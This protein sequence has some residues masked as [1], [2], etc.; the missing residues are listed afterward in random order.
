ML[1]GTENLNN[2]PIKTETD[3]FTKVTNDDQECSNVIKPEKYLKVELKYEKTPLND[4]DC[5]EKTNTKLET[6][7]YEKTESN[8]DNDSDDNNFESS[9]EHNES[10]TKPQQQ[11]S[12]SN[13]KKFFC[14]ICHSSYKQLMRLETHMI[15]KH[16][17]AKNLRICI[18]CNKWFAF[19]QFQQHISAHNPKFDC[20]LCS[21]R[22]VVERNLKIHI[23]TIHEEIK[24]F[25]CMLC[26]KSFT[27]KMCLQSHIKFKHTNK[28]TFNCNT[29]GNDFKSEYFLRKHKIVHLPL[30]EQ[31]KAYAANKPKYFSK[32]KKHICHYCGKISGNIALHNTHLMLH[33]GERPFKCEQCT[34][35]DKRFKTISELKRHTNLVHLGLRLHM[36]KVCGVSFGQKPHLKTHYRIHT[37]ERPY[38]CEYCEQD[39]SMR[40]V[41]LKH[42]RTHTG[43]RPYKCDK[44]F[45]CFIDSNSLKKHRENVHQIY[46]DRKQTR[47]FQKYKVENH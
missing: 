15:R 35:I 41:Y 4:D 46:S 45:E 9:F 28:P 3:V 44:C 40:A 10:S 7:Q 19:Q 16:K 23:R 5:E 39:F 47:L 36:C 6:Q 1:I 37:G 26:N 29:C 14:D 12:T 31:Q 11:Q 13:A 27:Q 21:K 17:M 18:D 8:D 43:E 22:F 32:Q 30:D 20:K 33:T 25:H 34:T 24:T 42:K 38:K 2:Q